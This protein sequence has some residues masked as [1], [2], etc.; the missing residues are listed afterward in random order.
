MCLR[1]S[2]SQIKSIYLAK[3]NIIHK[4]ALLYKYYAGLDHVLLVHFTSGIIHWCLCQ[5]V[6]VHH[7]HPLRSLY[8]RFVSIAY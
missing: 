4:R 1:A 3:S 5:T 8:R 2:T 6:S 7:V